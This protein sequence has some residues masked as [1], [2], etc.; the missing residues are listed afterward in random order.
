MK[1][2]SLP[3]ICKYFSFY[4]ETVTDIKGCGIILCILYEAKDNLFSFSHRFPSRWCIII[5]CRLLLLFSFLIC[6]LSV[7]F[8]SLA[9]ANQDTHGC[10][11][12]FK[13]CKSHI[14]TCRNCES[15]ILFLR[16]SKG[17]FS[18]T[19]NKNKLQQRKVEHTNA[20]SSKV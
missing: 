11:Y 8:A 18:F 3:K 16:F 7:L 10:V 1:S 12:I 19:W 15:N 20:I 5:R 13:S 6:D 4:R 14:P 17:F 9:F 2:P